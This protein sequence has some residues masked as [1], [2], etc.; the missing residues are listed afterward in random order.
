MTLTFQLRRSE[1]RGHR[2]LGWLRTFHTFTFATYLA[3]EKEH[4]SYGPIRVINEDRVSSGTGF[5]T[6]PHREFEIFSYVVSGELQHKDSMGNTEVLKRGD[7]QMTSAGTGISHSE[8]AHGSSD[9]H[10]LQIWAVPSTSDLTPNYFTRHFSD[11]EKRNQWACVVAP[12]DSKGVLQ[13]REG[14]GP[15]PICSALTLYA[16]IAERGQVLKQDLKGKKGYIQVIQSSGYN[17][18]AAVGANVKISG[19]GTGEELQLREGD[20]AYIVIDEDGATFSLENVG[21]EP[22]EVL[23][24][25]LE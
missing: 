23:L 21:E 7:I 19:S 17:T 11:D 18:G 20:S 10:F 8:M 15:A 1:A 22:A 13:T 24:F 3:H 25:D 16:T 14:T 6:H 2:E 9:V 5:G 4:E 12:N